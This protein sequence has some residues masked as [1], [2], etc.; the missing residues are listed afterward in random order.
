MGS[1][2]FLSQARQSQK[3]FHTGDSNNLRISSTSYL[4]SDSFQK[5]KLRALQ[6]KE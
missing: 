1:L 5:K 4:R 3:P 6:G 2:T